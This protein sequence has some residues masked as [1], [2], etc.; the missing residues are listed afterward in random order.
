MFLFYNVQ[1]HHLHTVAFL[2]RMQFKLQ[3]NARTTTVHACNNISHMLSSRIEFA[4]PIDVHTTVHMFPVTVWLAAH[5]TVHMFPVTVWLAAHTHNCSHVPCHSVTCCTY[6]NC[7]HVSCH[8]VTCCTYT[9]LF[10]C[11]LSQCDLL[12]IH[13]TVHML[14][15][16]VWLAAHTHNC[17]HVP[18]HSVTC[19]TYTQLFTCSLSQC[20]LLHIHTTVHSHTQHHDAPHSPQTM[21]HKKLS[22]PRHVIN[23]S[24]S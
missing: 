13:T 7:S 11:F 10:T 1:T 2:F 20:D 21:G 5:T 6:N 3:I 16:T 9:Q 8:S 18:C 15:V 14:S 12:H 23:N 22:F 4:M 17:S 19:C 24:R